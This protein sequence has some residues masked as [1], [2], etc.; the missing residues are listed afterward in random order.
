MP[1]ILLIRHG[2]TDFVKKH[3]LA[4]RMP[5][6]PLNKTGKV[7]AEAVAQFL[8]DEPIKTVYSSPIERAW[9]T[10]EPIARALNLEVITREGLIETEIGEWQNEPV[11]PLSKKKIWR[12]VQMAPSVFRFPGG[13]AFAETQF[14]ITQELLALSAMHEPKENIVCVSHADPIKLAIAY[15]LGL[16]M[17]HFQRIQIS[18]ASISILH[19]HEFGA[20]IG[21]LNLNA[22]RS[23]NLPK[24]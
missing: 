17:D 1:T 12:V 22:D 5:G 7:Q 4:G 16:P 3:R 6:I 21:A 13:E 20:H 15:F 14:R 2:E 23:L 9:Q 19:F 10:A 8:K 11:K 18:T 24:S